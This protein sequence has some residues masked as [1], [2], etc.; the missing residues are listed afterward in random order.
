MSRLHD[1]PPA[2]S[3]LTA[4]FTLI[5]MSIVLVIIGLIVGS[6]LV[7]RNLIRA[8]EVR[9]IISDIEKFNTAANT[10]R[11]KYDCIPGDCATAT[12]YFPA[13]S[14]GCTGGGVPSVSATC[15]GNGNGVVDDTG[16][17]GNSGYAETLLF[18][19]HLALAGLIPGSY[20]GNSYYPPAV[21]SSRI[22]GTCYSMTNP[23]N[24]ILAPYTFSAATSAPNVFTFGSP[25]EPDNNWNSGS[26][27]M[28]G[29]GAIGTADAYGLDLKIDDGHP[30]TGT[31]TVLSNLDVP[32]SVYP[33]G[34]GP[35]PCVNYTST[36]YAYNLA[37][38]GNWC[39]LIFKAQF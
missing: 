24:G 14:G 15:N 31:V 21:P 8:A 10:F 9:S 2:K 5:E 18:W 34:F 38:S 32:K 17:A 11:G 37:L 26:M 28:W 19:Q 4:A 33:S 12:N 23:A 1:A 6:V 35:N 13:V 7:G 20:T 30:D 3:A 16:F 22:S 29:Y 36:P 39:M 25:I 27:C